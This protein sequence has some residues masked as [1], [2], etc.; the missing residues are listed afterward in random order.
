MMEAKRGN[1]YKT[2]HVNKLSLEKEGNLPRYRNL[3]QDVCVQIE[4]CGWFRFCSGGMYV[5]T[6][7]TFAEK[8]VKVVHVSSPCKYLQLMED[9][10]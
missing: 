8:G 2:P 6:T 9:V 10:F 5:W 4:E 1:S 7:L 3:V